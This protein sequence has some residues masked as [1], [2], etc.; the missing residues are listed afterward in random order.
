M[1]ICGSQCDEFAIS[2]AAFGLTMPDQRPMNIAS[3]DARAS[4][5]VSSLGRLQTIPPVV[6]QAL[7]KL[8]DPRFSSLDL[9]KLISADHSITARVIAMANTAHFEDPSSLGT[10]GEAIMCLGYRNTQAIL[11]AA[12]A[13]TVLCRPVT[14]RGMERNELWTH[15]MTCAIGSGVIAKE[16]G[17]CDPDEAYVAGLLH[18]V[19][20][21]AL[22]SFVRRKD[23]ILELIRTADYPPF[24][25]EQMVLGFDHAHLGSLICRNWRLADDLVFAVSAHHEPLTKVGPD[26]LSAVVN[27]ADAISL[28]PGIRTCGQQGPVNLDMTVVEWLGLEPG[29]VRRVVPQIRASLKELAEMS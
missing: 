24:M 7:E 25:A 19:G 1:V 29:E 23:K 28:S 3:S 5:M 10:V 6:T 18:D 16:F 8:T 20:L 4:Q 17:L 12:S 14:L 21:P 9:A 22:E 11:C 2:G 13:Y 27:V 26:V 15:S